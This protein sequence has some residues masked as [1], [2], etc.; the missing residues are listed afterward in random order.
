MNLGKRIKGPFYLEFTP[1]TQRKLA[2][3]DN[4]CCRNGAAAIETLSRLCTQLSEWVGANRE[5]VLYGAR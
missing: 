1:S 5:L 3:C 4:M 2:L